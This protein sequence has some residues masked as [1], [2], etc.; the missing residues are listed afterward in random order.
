MALPE[1]INIFAALLAGIFSFLSPCVLPLVPSYIAFISG[2]S[3]G[4]LSTSG[5]EGT[6][7]GIKKTVILNAIFFILGFSLIFVALGASATFLGKFIARN[8]RGMEII[9]GVTIILMG[10]HFAGA[11]KINFL[12]R[13]R[14][15]HLKKKPLG[16]LGT[17]LVGMAF[18]A[19]WTPCVGPLLGSILML[20]ATTQ[21]VNKGV[22]LLT[23]YSIGLGLPFLIAG[24]LIHH[25]FE[26]FRWVRKY[27]RPISIG[28]GILLILVGLTLIIGYFGFLSSFGHNLPF[29]GPS[30]KLE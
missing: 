17:V 16:I 24:L 29:V 8:I 3:I 7:R 9:G 30:A 22:V 1:N 13:E 19:A 27:F 15:V 10:L 28:A 6:A 5:K 2:V 11:M 23:V 21:T 25:F 26:Y 20:A 18:A 12:Y 14:A 4:E